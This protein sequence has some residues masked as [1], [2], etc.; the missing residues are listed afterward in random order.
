MARRDRER[1][2]HLRDIRKSLGEN[3]GDFGKRFGKTGPAVSNYET[4]RLPEDKMLKAIYDM[5]FSI[6]WLISGEGRMRRGTGE[7]EDVCSSLLEGVGDGLMIVQD[8]IYKF[9]NRALER[10]TGYAVDE[11]IGHHAG[12]HAIPEERARIGRLF[13]MFAQGNALPEHD[14]FTIQCKDGTVK[15]VKICYSTVHYGGKPAILGIVRDTIAERQG[16][17][18]FG[19]LDVSLTRQ[20]RKLVRVLKV[21]LLEM[22]KE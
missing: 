3:Q 17:S 6:D 14:V 13:A 10:I 19:D 22:L 15:N 16:K 21:L 12:L 9:V 20:E 2:R 11:L 5:G 1:G 18:E 4:G 8:G 7:S